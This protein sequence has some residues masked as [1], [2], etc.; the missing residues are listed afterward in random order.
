MPTDN[1][2]KTANA[3]L[4]LT[5]FL[6][7][8]YWLGS[9]LARRLLGG[10]LLV[11]ALGALTATLV[12]LAIDYRQE[13]GG[14]HE[15]LQAVQNSSAGSM[16]YALWIVNPAALRTQM[17]DLLRLPNIRH[18]EVVEAD[19]SQYQAGRSVLPERD[20]VERV[21]KL[22]YV[23]PLSGRVQLMG[24][25]RL[26]ATTAEIK[27]RLF[28][29]FVVIL[30][31]QGTKT[32]VVSCFILVFFQ[33]LVTRHLH[34]LAEQARRVNYLNLRAPLT[35]DREV[36]NDE[37]NELLD[38]FNQMRRNL[39]RD[40]E[41]WEKSGRDT[42]NENALGLQMA[43]QLP[44]A[45]VRVDG[46]G[47][48]SWMNPAAERL[49]GRP[50]YSIVNS[51]LA[52]ALPSAAG[53]ASWSAERIFIDTLGSSVPVRRRVVFVHNDGRIISCDASATMIG[54]ASESA[55]QDRSA[56][57]VILLSAPQVL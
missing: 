40:I 41:L 12:Q 7:W 3:P 53:F 35:L 46:R 9:V 25:A 54:E 55:A 39:L 13:V 37:L 2:D 20:R 42:A 21:F 34:R 24:T 57:L 11:S 36:A 8:R 50:A 43:T 30:L 23:H 6:R 27:S 16:A 10:V 38:A 49:C 45:I 28:S 47:A 31:T 4:V 15:Q 22:E 56:G 33:W 26:E 1:N 29:R 32:F 52:A 17:N 48:V 44:E 14:V 19:G 5:R 51:A 18:V